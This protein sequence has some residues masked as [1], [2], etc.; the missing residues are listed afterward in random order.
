MTSEFGNESARKRRS[1][2]LVRCLRLVTGLLYKSL[3][4]LLL[5]GFFTPLALFLRLIRRGALRLRLDSQVESYWIDRR[6]PG[7]LPSSMSNLY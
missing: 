4:A 2:I 1:G 6:P 5:Y 7:P 3:V